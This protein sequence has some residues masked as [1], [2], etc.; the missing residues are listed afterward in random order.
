MS[1]SVENPPSEGAIDAEQLSIFALFG[2]VKIKQAWA[3]LVVICLLLYGSWE[4]G[5]YMTNIG[6]EV[7]LADKDADYARQKVEIAR[8]E[9]LV[10]G[11]SDKSR[12]DLLD[13]ISR[14]LELAE[15]E[16][17]RLDQELVIAKAVAEAAERKV[18]EMANLSEEQ[19]KEFAGDLRMAYV[20]LAILEKELLRQ[21][22][23]SNAI[24]EPYML[25]ILSDGHVSPGRE[26]IIRDIADFLGVD[27]VLEMD[28]NELSSAISLIVT[29]VRK[30]HWHRP[31]MINGGALSGLRSIGIIDRSDKLTL[32]GFTVIK[33]L[34]RE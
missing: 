23:R 4:V 11:Q 18:E 10:G 14:R 30:T 1:D 6:N 16:R 2:K 24:L 21:A 3:F 8:L 33:R 22:E 19:R 26:E 31:T 7:E 12:D 25:S 15:E 17:R 5:C 32:L 28:F 20:Q 9:R 13:R 34:L 29:D 27:E